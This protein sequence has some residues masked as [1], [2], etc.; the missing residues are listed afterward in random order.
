MSKQDDEAV[1]VEGNEED[2]VRAGTPDVEA[3]EREDEAVEPKQARRRK[4]RHRAIPLGREVRHFVA[5]GLEVRSKGDTGEITVSG[6]PIVYGVPYTVRDAFGSFEETM[7]PGCASDILERGV[8]TRLLLNHEGLPMARSTAGTLKLWD[9]ADSLNFE[10]KLDARQQLANDFAIAVERGDITQMSVGMVVGRDTWGESGGMETRDIHG[11]DDL[12]DVSG[13]TYPCSDTTTIEI[14]KRMA[15]EMPVESRARLRRFEVALRAGRI[16]PDELAAVL[17]ILQGHEER[18]GKTLSG[19]NKTHVEAAAKSIHS[20][21]EAAGVDPNSLIDGDGDEGLMD[22]GSEGGSSG[23]GAAAAQ[24][25]T[26]AR[27]DAIVDPGDGIR[28]TKTARV[29]AMEL[30]ARRHRRKAA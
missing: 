6:R 16:T 4:D 21:L 26:L 9:T 13:V 24:D 28:A 10:A 1:Q 23:D 15:L 25:G 2:E 8:D 12:L 20:L 14:A 22:D 30:E 27:P 7:R 17:A 29:L 3:E 18:A 11:L 19:A 5:T